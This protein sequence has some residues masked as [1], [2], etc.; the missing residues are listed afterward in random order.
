MAKKVRSREGEHPRRPGRKNARKAPAVAPLQDKA[1]DDP[2]GLYLR[3]ISKHSLLTREGEVLIAKRIEVGQNMVLQSL[4]GS[5]VAVE[6]ARH[7]RAAMLDGSLRVKAVL[8]GIG[9]LDPG[10]DG[11]EVHDEATHTRRAVKALERVGFLERKSTR[12]QRELGKRRLSKSRRQVLRQ[13]R[14]RALDQIRELLLEL[15]LS[16]KLLGSMTQS[17]RIQGAELERQMNEIATFETRTGMGVREIG[18]SVR[19]AEKTREARCTLEARTG[20]KV[21]ELMAMEQRLLYARRRVREMETRSCRTRAEMIRTNR[22]LTEG[23]QLVDR[24]R[25][26]M[27]RGNLRLVVSI[28]RRY[29]NRG[30]AFLDL[31]QEGNLGLMR[32]VDKFEYR[33]GYKFST[34][35]TWW[36]RQ[37][38]SRA[39]ADQARTIRV[40]VH[41]MELI[42]KLMRASRILVQDLGREPSPEEISAT[43]QLPLRL[44]R[45]VLEVSRHTISLETPVGMEDGSCLADFIEDQQTIDPVD[46]LEQQE[47]AAQTRRALA[48]LTPRE[49]KI[50]RMRYG[51][52]EESGHTLE[53]VGRN[54][55]VTRERIRQIQAKALNK[56]SHPKRAGWLR[57]FW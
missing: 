44:I 9:R 2:L 3:Q 33:R 52:G 51:V 23:L 29:L 4:L 12:L 38:I 39:V 32:A 42:N 15:G 40:P 47:L 27:V 54:F 46:G 28:A 25:A 57:P 26:E 37:A 8:G 7:L 30:L 6:K 18:R 34:Y 11:E 48:A 10:P 31:I 53:E 50:L 41:M 35:A 55:H 1:D 36:I 16:E 22:Q 20:L 43:L 14:I 13:Q 24:S 17:L 5:H 45:K 49:E 56:L 19:L 21:T